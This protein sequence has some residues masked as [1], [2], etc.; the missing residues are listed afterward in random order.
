MLR[1]RQGSRDDSVASTSS[2]VTSMGVKP[3]GRSH[4][5]AG[6]EPRLCSRAMTE[7]TSRVF[8]A[9]SRVGMPGRLPDQA[10]A[11]YGFKLR[12]LRS[13][14]DFVGTLAQALMTST[15]ARFQRSPVGAVSPSATTDPAGPA[16]P[17]VCWVQKVSPVAVSSVWFSSA[18]F[19]PI[20]RGVAVS[21]SLPAPNTREPAAVVVSDTPGAPLAAPLLAVAPV[22]L[23][24][25]KAMTVRVWSKPPTAGLDVTCADVSTPGAVAFQISASP[26]CELA[27]ATSVQV[28]PAP[29]TVTDWPPLA[30]PSDSAKASSSSPAAPVWN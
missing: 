29:L 30:G 23:V 14:G 9:P 26:A 3:A 19:G 7:A 25:C 22:P 6:T 28:R 16:G 12:G 20:V 5:S 15:A 21:Q 10:A 24:P 13:A 2:R 11:G 1:I 4:A 17:V 27:R 8:I 18:W